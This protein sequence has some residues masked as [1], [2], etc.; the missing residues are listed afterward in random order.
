MKTEYVMPVS[1][2]KG[3]RA[4]FFSEYSHLGYYNKKDKMRKKTARPAIFLA[5]RAAQ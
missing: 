2:L 4:D 5:G 1:L 3:K